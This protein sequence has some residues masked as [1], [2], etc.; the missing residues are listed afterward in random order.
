MFS[1]KRFYVL[2]NVSL[3]IKINS[4]IVKVKLEKENL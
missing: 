2:G 4:L 1:G 3:I